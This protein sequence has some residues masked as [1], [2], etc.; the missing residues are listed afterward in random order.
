MQE[1]D[2]AAEEAAKY[3]EDAANSD[4]DMPEKPVSGIGDDGE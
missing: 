3:E 2:A 4:G 1:R